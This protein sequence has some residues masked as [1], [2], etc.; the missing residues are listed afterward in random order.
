MFLYPLR[1]R[2]VG[3]VL[4]R[5]AF[6]SP[7]GRLL[8]TAD[9]SRPQSHSFLGHVAGRLQIK[10]S[11]SGDENDSRHLRSPITDRLRIF[12]KRNRSRL[13]RFA[14][15]VRFLIGCARSL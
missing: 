3:F 7:H 6:I 13:F 8:N 5:H 9:H 11:G 1:R 10:P 4:V 14:R 12:V 15:S 2:P